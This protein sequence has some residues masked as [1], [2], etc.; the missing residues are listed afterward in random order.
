M[1]PVITTFT[2]LFTTSIA[3]AVLWH[4][5]VKSY[6]WATIISALSVGLINT[7]GYAIVRG[8]FPHWSILAVNI[9]LAAA[10][11]LGVGIPFNRRRTGRGLGSH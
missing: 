9:T 10:L 8:H 4:A 3:G 1:D 5:L 7:W 6:A 2:V 11:A